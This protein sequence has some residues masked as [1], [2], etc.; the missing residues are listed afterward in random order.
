MTAEMIPFPAARRVDLIRSI[1]RRALELPPQAG[2]HHIVRSVDLQATV[3][4]RKGVAEALIVQER[5]SLEST[6]RRH[7]WETVM[8]TRGV[9]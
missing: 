9:R 7:L 3:L 5:I 6:I 1:V 8:R 4:R 2:E